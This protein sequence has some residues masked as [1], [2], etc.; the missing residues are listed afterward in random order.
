M[1]C[2]ILVNASKSVAAKMSTFF[3]PPPLFRT[4]G[5]VNLILANYLTIAEIFAISAC[6]VSGFD[7]ISIRTSVA[8]SPLPV[9]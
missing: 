2:E 1:V 3:S 4:D 6:I 9:T 7:R 8:L 5:I